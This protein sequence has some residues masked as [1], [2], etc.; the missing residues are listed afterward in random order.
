M[1][2]RRRRR[3]RTSA[4]SEWKLVWLRGPPV[5]GAV[6]GNQAGSATVGYVRPRRR[7]HDDDAVFETDEDPEVD[8]EPGQPRGE[9]RQLQSIDDG[10]GAATP[11][12]CHRALVRIRES[13]RLPARHGAT[14]RSSGCTAFLHGDGA[15]TRKSVAVLV[16]DEGGVADD[17]RMRVTGH[18]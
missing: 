8:G 1:R 10:N 14:D 17:E 4:R 5:L 12:R 7:N 15:D 2:G 9:A 3:L 6:T 18:T 16:R 13:E 11:D